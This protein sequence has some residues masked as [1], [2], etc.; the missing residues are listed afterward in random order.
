MTGRYRPP[1]AG[2]ENIHDLNI[3]V[4]GLVLTGIGV[5]EIQLAARCVSKHGGLVA[6]A[7]LLMLGLAPDA[8]EPTAGRCHRCGYRRTSD[9]HRAICGRHK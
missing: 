7:L 2:G 9:N 4:D 3:Q 6:G 5:D 1:R 8:P